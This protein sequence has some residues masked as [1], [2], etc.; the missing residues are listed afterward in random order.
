MTPLLDLLKYF[1]KYPTKA[2]V[3][4]NFARTKTAEAIPGYT[5]LQVY[6]DAL[7]AA[8]MPEITSFVFSSDEKRVSEK[9]R[10]IAGYFMLFEYGPIAISPPDSTRNRDQDWNLAITFGYPQ[11][12]AGNDLMSEALIMDKL[13]SLAF[14]LKTQ[15]ELDNKDLCASTRFAESSINILAT[16]PMLLYENYGVVVSF[17]KNIYPE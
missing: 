9:L 5:D 11:N 17:T 7:P 8:L 13:Y 1:A 15:M 4:A 3:L 14:Q 12:K 2:A 6:L 16:E 10:N